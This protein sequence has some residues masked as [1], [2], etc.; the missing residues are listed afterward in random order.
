MKNLNDALA[1]QEADATEA[2]LNA[3]PELNPGESF[4]FA[5]HPEVPCFNACCSDLTLMLTPYDVLRLRRSLNISSTDFLNHF[6]VRATLP[7]T[8]FPMPRLKMREERLKRCPFVSPEG[9]KVYPNRPGACRT[10]PLG[11]A[12]RLD[13]A[14]AVVEQFFIVREPHC[15][16]FEEASTWTAP[17][18]LADQDLTAYNAYND[19]YMR[20]MS[21]ARAKQAR[22]SDKQEQ[23]VWLAQYQPDAFQEF[24]ASRDLFRLV[25]ID[26]AR[27]AR[28]LAEEEEALIFGIDWLELVFFGNEEGLRRKRH[29]MP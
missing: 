9:C 11:R 26:E 3:L 12:S 5:C 21:L 13:E 22:L 23:M 16:G 27:Q 6:A 28:V 1:E 2:F 14:G 18:W 25:E 8:G 4:R 19:R 10:Y 15:Q 7:D 29:P 20:M 24:I 17:N